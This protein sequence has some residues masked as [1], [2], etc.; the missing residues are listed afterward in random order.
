LS[1]PRNWLEEVC[2]SLDIL[3]RSDV[4]LGIDAHDGSDVRIINGIVRRREMHP[5]LIR[6]VANSNEELAGFEQGKAGEL[7]LTF[8]FSPKQ[9]A[10]W[11]KLP[12]RFK[13][14]EHAD[15]TV[16]RSTLSRI[17]NIAMS[18]GA[19]VRCED[20]IFQKIL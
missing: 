4:R 8:V 3:D 7:D 14:E 18:L 2:G 20:G 12:A 6:P 10:H 11:D 9:K 1:D 19:L 16:P 17:K 13:F 15:K 5:I